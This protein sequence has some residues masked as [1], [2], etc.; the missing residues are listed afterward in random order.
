[1]T[2]PTPEPDVSHLMAIAARVHELGG[3]GAVYEATYAVLGGWDP[4]AYRQLYR[5]FI[6]STQANLP[7]AGNQTTAVKGDPLEDVARYFLERGGVARDVQKG[8]LSNRWTI[9]GKGEVF[10]DRIDRI[11]GAGMAVVAGPNLYMEAKN[12]I[13]PMGPADWAQHCGRMSSH[14]CTFGVAFSAAGF[15]FGSG[16]GYAGDLFH[17]W[18][19]GRIHIL[20]TVEELRRVAV[21]GIFPWEVLRTAFLRQR[22][23]G[24]ED[25]KVQKAIS[26]KACL[27]T[28]ADEHAR[29]T[30]A[31][32]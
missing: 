14:G 5:A 17:D 11:L 1:M 3:M 20:I 4:A 25:A 27:K 15:G 29:L 30:L 32:P 24:Y 31:G 6:T 26:K 19:R 23:Q 9:D 12:H 7:A 28:A 2:A 22:D 18:L 21:D 8:G 16:K 13:A 10:P